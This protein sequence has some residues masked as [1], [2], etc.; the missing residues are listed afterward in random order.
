MEA[1]EYIINGRKW[2]YIKT[3]KV[4]PL[5]DNWS[6]DYYCGDGD[7]INLYIENIE[8]QKN[9]SHLPTVKGFTLECISGIPAS[10]IY[11]DEIDFRM[12]WEKAGLDKLIESPC[13]ELQCI[14]IADYLCRIFCEYRE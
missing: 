9:N 11:V 3:S 7:G 13:Y 4:N 6:A 12:F 8:E 10:S 5:I 2:S 14:M 1:K